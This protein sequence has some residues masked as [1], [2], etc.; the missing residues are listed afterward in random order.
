[1]V[2]R[3]RRL[4]APGDRHGEGDERELYVEGVAI[5]RPCR[6]SGAHQARTASRLGRRSVRGAPYPPAMAA[7]DSERAPKWRGALLPIVLTAILAWAGSII[8]VVVTARYNYAAQNRDSNLR[9]A[10]QRREADAAFRL[11]AAQI[12][13]SQPTC[14][15]ALARVVFLR[16][17]FPQPD[18]FG[19]T[20]KGAIPASAVA[21]G[22]SGLVKKVWG[23][24]Q[25]RFRTTG[26]FSSATVRG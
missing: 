20:I 11:S 18:K 21:G 7:D 15:L 8:A 17:V 4:G 22:S 25:G 6:G 5:W 1:M 16:S 9:V 13:M 14:Q 23:S 12:V 10:L 24:G 3:G 19:C 26:K 2:R